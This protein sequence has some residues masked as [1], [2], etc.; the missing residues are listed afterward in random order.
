MH[1]YIYI[2]IEINISK[3]IVRHY[4]QKYT[5]MDV[6]RLFW[7]TSKPHDLGATQVSGS[8]DCT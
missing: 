3:E 2:H 5:Y 6:L 4:I 7:H 1:I 8:T